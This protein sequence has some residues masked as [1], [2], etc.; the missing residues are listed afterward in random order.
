MN[1]ALESPVFTALDAVTQT[2]TGVTYLAVGIAAVL[3]L[4]RD[5]RTRLFLGVALANAGGFA[6][7][8]V[9]WVYGTRDILSLGRVPIG[10]MLG[11]IVLGSL[12]LFHF[13]QVFPRHRPWILR[14]RRWLLAGYVV[15]P[16]ATVGLVA[17]GPP[18]EDLQNIGLFLLALV[19]IGLPMIV[20]AGIVLPIGGIISL[21][22]SYRESKQGET[23]G[24]RTPLLW[25]LVSQIAGGTIALIFAPV[26]AVV[27]PTPVVQTALKIVV[28]AFG[29]MT[30]AAFA[31]AVWKSVLPEPV[32]V[33]D[34]ACGGP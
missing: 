7:S 11:S 24:A 33:T 8:I 15:A 3:K 6:V 32:A 34:R 2:I 5:I 20:L 28:A 13:C 23:A 16:L 12:L 4:P 26:L 30:P 27:A 17:A 29:I 18:P 25:L 1:S 31:V 19:V 22:K 21:V 9:A 10:T 14:F